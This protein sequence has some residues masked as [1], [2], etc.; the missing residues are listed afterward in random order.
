M[1]L[2][3]PHDNKI[4]LSVYLHKYPHTVILRERGG[5]GDT[6]LVSACAGNLC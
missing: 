2:S 1:Y 3:A 6:Q 4:A 5:G